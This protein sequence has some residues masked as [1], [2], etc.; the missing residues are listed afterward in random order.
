MRS[1]REARAVAKLSHPNVVRVFDVVEAGQGDPWIV[2]EYLQG[3]SLSE[4]L[5]AQG[6]LP[7]HR[8]AKIGL[9][10]L[11]A[12][13]AA[14]EVGVIHRDVK[15]GNV[16]L[17]NDG[18]AVLTDFGI[19]T[20]PGD[21]YVTRT[22]LLIGSPAYIAPE[23]AGLA[24]HLGFR[25]AAPDR[26]PADA[27]VVFH[28]SAS[29][30]GLATAQQAF[31]GWLNACDPDASGACT[32]AHRRNMLGAGFRAIGIARAFGAG[33]AYGWYWTTDF[34]GVVDQVVTPP[35]GP[36]T[37][38]APA[39]GSFGA[40][41]SSVPST[42]PTPTTTG[43]SSECSCWCRCRRWPSASSRP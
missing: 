6:T 16:L 12:L 18:R 40:T 22:G 13:S 28:T 2:M 30:A 25:F 7:P 5:A 37:P 29:A 27:D 19:A 26:A 14:H 1:M 34:G 9:E 11:Q 8:V 42:M 23:R 21:P 24:A 36:V 10:I 35:G 17:A 3:Q 38:S 31:D 39:I 41:P 32:Y 33:T 43:S 4:I 15:P 20:L